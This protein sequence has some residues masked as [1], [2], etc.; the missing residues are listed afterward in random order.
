M[1]NFLTDDEMISSVSINKFIGMWQRGGKVITL[2]DAMLT[3]LIFF[4]PLS[5]L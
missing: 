5:S 4:V 1:L 2:E 3:V